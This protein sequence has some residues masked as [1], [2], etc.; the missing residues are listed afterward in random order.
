MSIRIMSRVWEFYP[1]GGTDLLSMLAM[2]D[3]SDDEGR[4][5][6][7]MASISKK[8]R[9]SRSQA[10]RVVHGLI[11]EGFIRVV[12]N[13]NGGA[14]GASRQ[15]QIILERLRGSTHATGSVHATGRTHTQ[16]GSHACG[17]TGSAH[18]TQT[19]NEP[20]LTVSNTNPIGLVVGNDVPNKLSPASEINECPHQK[21]IGLYAEIIPNGIQPKVWNGTRAVHLKARWREDKKRQNLDYWRRLFNYIAQS[22]FLMGQAHDTNKRPFEI[23]LDWIIK[24]DIFAKI[25]EGKY[26]REVA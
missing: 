19:V 25:I 15:Y 2:A 14:P 1:G 3:W 7:S 12:G 6:P 10:Q 4:C 16:E 5:Y 20:S 8:V 24:P 26:H 17:E 13:E 21:I 23:S 11:Q 22:P 18:A 9:L